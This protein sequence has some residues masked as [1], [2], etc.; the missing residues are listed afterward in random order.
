MT[1]R[2]SRKLALPRVDMEKSVVLSVVTTV[3]KDSMNELDASRSVAI[4]Q[5][6]GDREEQGGTHDD[7]LPA[8]HC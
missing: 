3:C 7:E 5:E 8:Y 1:P 6:A 2:P 4:F